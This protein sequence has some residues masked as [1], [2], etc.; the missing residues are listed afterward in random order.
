VSIDAVNGGAV[1]FEQRHELVG[2]VWEAFSVYSENAMASNEWQ[3][4]C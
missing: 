4:I 1:C 3:F 2:F